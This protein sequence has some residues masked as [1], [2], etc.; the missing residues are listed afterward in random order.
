MAPDRVRPSA[1]DVA[2]AAFTTFAVVEGC[3]RGVLCPGL[4]PHPRPGNPSPDYFNEHFRRRTQKLLGT[5]QGMKRGSC[6]RAGTG[7]SH[8]RGLLLHI[9]LRTSACR[10]ATDDKAGH[11]CTIESEQPSSGLEA[12]R[13][14]AEMGKPLSGPDALERAAWSAG[15]AFFAA[16]MIGGNLTPENIP[17]AQ[18][19]TLAGLAGIGSIVLTVLES[20]ALGKYKGFWSDMVVRLFKTFIATFTAAIAAERLFTIQDF[21]WQAALNLA[22]IAALT[23]LGKGV[24]AAEPDKDKRTPSTL[25]TATYFEVARSDPPP[26]A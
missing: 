7:Y 18:S 15:Q 26:A 16:I 6:G 23:A 17:W 19:L 21:D 8:T 12:I 9:V 1:G 2:L 22:F 14:E 5:A 25:P 24:L 11:G 4:R 13:E 20:F 10:R 3:P